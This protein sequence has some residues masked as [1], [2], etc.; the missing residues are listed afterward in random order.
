MATG[1]WASIVLICADDPT[2]M[3]HMA[4]NQNCVPPSTPPHQQEFAIGGFQRTSTDAGSSLD[5]AGLR[6][7]ARNSD[8][9]KPSMKFPQF[10]KLYQVAHRARAQHVSVT[11]HCR[12]DE[13]RALVLGP[14]LRS[15]KLSSVLRTVP[16]CRYFT[17]TSHRI[18][19]ELE[20]TSTRVPSS[21]QRR[22]GTAVRRA[23]RRKE[24]FWLVEVLWGL[25]GFLML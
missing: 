19:E 10:T 15:Q 16:S 7:V 6:R 11:K 12:C 8:F 3:M 24:R 21:A 14:V 2:R 22:C 4:L 18:E 9:R 1:A 5:L 25:A 13:M 23:A 20:I 17:R